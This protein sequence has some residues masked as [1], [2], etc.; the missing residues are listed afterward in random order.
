MTFE[1]QIWLT[2][3]PLI[4]LL[5]AGLFAFGLRRREALLSRFAAARLLDQL[6]EKASHQRTLLKAALI[7]LAFALIGISLARPQYGV[8]WIERKARGLD[9]VF[10]LDSSKSMLATDLRPTRLD[11]AKLAIID[12]VKRLE[13]DRIGLVAFAGNAFLQTPPTLDY[14]AFRENLDAIGYS[15]ISRGGSDIGRA[16]R[17]AAKAFPKDNSFKVVVLLTD[18][19]DQQQDVITA[20]RE[21]ADEGIKVYTIGIG[22]PEGDYLKIRNAQGDDEFIRDSSGQPVRSQLDESTL[23]KIAQLTGGSYSRLSDQSL[24]T[25]YNSVL[26]TLPREERQSELQE[27]RI[28]RY[29]WALSIACILMVVEIFIRRRS[30]LSLSLLL[31]L[32]ASSVCTPIRSEAQDLPVKEIQELPMPVAEDTPE[33]LVEAPETDP[34]ILYNQAHH[35]LTT[36]NYEQATQLLEQAIENSTQRSLQRDALYNMAHASNQIGET[37]LQAQDFESAIVRWKQAEALFQSA[38]EIDSNDANSLEDAAATA[39]RRTALEDFLKQQEQQE[40]SSQEDEQE[41]QESEDSSDSEEGEDNQESS[42]GEDSSGDDQEP[43]EDSQTADEDSESEQGQSSDASDQ[44]SESEGEDEG[45]ESDGQSGEQESESTRNPAEDME[46]QAED[47][48]DSTGSENEALPAE[49]STANQATAGEA[50]SDGE[51]AEMTVQGMSI[52]EA[53]DLLD[54]LRGEERLLP[55]SEPSEATQRSNRNRDIR[56]W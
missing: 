51:A 56:D 49:D 10:V 23:Q 19:E 17:E 43:S 30:N 42:D 40:Q 50:G 2:L 15:S 4:V 12:L 18:G 38:N 28:E 8:D 6:T 41:Q 33:I 11:R 48:E 46:Q 13:S 52:S 26:A 29:Q 31:L 14:A 9:I 3:T 44:P 27:A 55:F 34:R 35:Q 7:L 21:V 47:A 22:T 5:F 32:S 24:N 36:G 1:N 20:A 39:A 37:A 25:L 45:S 16:I 54:S 53:Q